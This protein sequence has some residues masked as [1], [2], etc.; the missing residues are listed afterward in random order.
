VYANRREKHRNLKAKARKLENDERKRELVRENERETALKVSVRR[1][2]TCHG[3]QWR[4][5]EG[6]VA[7]GAA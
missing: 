1:E 5:I 4:Q 7:C 6:N 3:E 2:M